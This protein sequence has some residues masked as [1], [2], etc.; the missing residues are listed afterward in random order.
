MKYRLAKFLIAV[1]VAVLAGAGCETINY[2]YRAPL[3]DAGRKCVT[4]CSGIKET[5]RGNEMQIAQRE[6]ESCERTSDIKYKSCLSHAQN[7][8]QIHD[9]DKE[10]K[11]KTCWAMDT[12][13]RCDDNY[14][15]C[16]VNCGGVIIETKQ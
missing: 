10:R 9:C 4:Q 14:R 3:S 12:T 15:T 5:C 16:F 8:E 2:E 7:K 11:N 6:K 1:V 13:Y